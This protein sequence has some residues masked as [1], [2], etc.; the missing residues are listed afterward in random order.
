MAALTLPMAFSGVVVGFL[1]ILMIGRAGVLPVNL[2]YGFGGLVI[3]YLY[4]LNYATVRATPSAT[5]VC[6]NSMISR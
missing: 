4:F 3:A 5:R 1:A 2:A 6:S